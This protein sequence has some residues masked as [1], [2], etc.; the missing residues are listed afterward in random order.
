MRKTIFAIVLTACL[1]MAFFATGAAQ[2]VFKRQALDDN[3][4][5]TQDPIIYDQSP[6]AVDVISPCIEAGFGEQDSDRATPD[7]ADKRPVAQEYWEY[8]FTTQADR[9]KWYWVSYP[10]LNSVTNNAL[11]ASEF[12]EDL[13]EV[14]QVQENGEWHDT[15]TYLEEIDWMVQSG[16]QYIN[17]DINTDDW[18]DNYNSHIVSSPQGYKVMM[19]SRTPSIVTLRESGLRTSSETQFPIYGGQVENWLGYFREDS[20]WPHDVFAS[21][22][23]DIC[24]IKTKNWCLVRS[25]PVGDYWGMHGKM[26]SLK[27]GDMVIVTTL[28]D[29]TFQWNNA[30]ATPPETKALPEYFVFDEKQDYVPVYLSIPDSLMTGLKEIGLY[31]D[32][33]CK[34][35]VVIEDNLEQI[36]A[37]LDIGEQLTDGV[38]EF[39]FYYNDGKSQQ[40]EMKTVRLDPSRICARFV[41][42]NK[43][44]PYFDINITARDMDNMVPPELTLGQNYPNP[45][46]PSTT[47]SYQL[48]A[49]GPVRLDIYNVRGQLVRTLIDAEQEAGYHSVVW[50]G[51]DN[52]GQSVASGIYFYRLSSPAQTLGKR[53]LLMK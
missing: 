27:D 19:L 26:T 44:Y 29:H 17:W 18:T 6:Q 35:A 43:R 20:A 1:L 24:M 11:K 12:F 21:I 45:F 41:N 28:N 34:G 13:L 4:Q 7:I 15:P 16:L 39:V 23:D 9:E 36:C 42:G 53:M 40:Q 10:V 52:A 47:I 37:Y 14:H 22:W 49:S 50:N 51:T 33:V 48:P 2:R 46:N 38:V 32:G 31:L 8:K 30:D 5:T 3:Y 25:N